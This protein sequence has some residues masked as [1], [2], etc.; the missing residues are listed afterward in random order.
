MKTAA[1][2]LKVDLHTHTNISKDGGQTPQELVDTAISLGFD[3][4]AVTDHNTVKG[5]LIAEKYAKGKPIIIF[6]GQEIETRQG[7]IIVLNVR[8][9]IQPYRDL[10]DTIMEAKED[11]GFII[12][13]HPFDLM[14]KGIGKNLDNVLKQIDVIE[15]FN[16][17]TIW[18]AFNNR[19]REYAEK[20]KK[21]IIAASDSHFT[22]EINKSYTLVSSK[23][24]PDAILNAITSGNTEYVMKAQSRFSKFMRGFRKIRSYV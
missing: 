11:G 23:K 8:E 13:P 2:K 4:I 16:S 15:G 10:V 3:A 20:A 19:A 14:R 24:N 18:T 21:P 5:G 17:R 22:N 1:R 9:T 7:E 12:V 6:P